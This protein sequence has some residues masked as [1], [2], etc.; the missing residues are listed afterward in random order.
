M[1]VNASGQLETPHMTIGRMGVALTTPTQ[2][3][4]LYMAAAY[5]VVASLDSVRLIFESLRALL[6]RKLAATPGGPVAIIAMTY[7]QAQLGWGA[8]AQF[9]GFL[10]ANLAVFNLLP[11]P[12]LDGFVLLLLGFEAVI[13]RR[14]DARLEYAAKVTGFVLLMGLIV[15]FTF[16][17]LFNLITHGTP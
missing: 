11:V 2:P 12:P 10:S 15:T 4:A 16:N 9:G 7:E 17:D 5:G 1:K 14:I 6:S 3:V 13:R 8:V